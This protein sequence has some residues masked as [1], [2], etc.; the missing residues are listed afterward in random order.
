MG[1]LRPHFLAACRPDW[2]KM[3]CKTDPNSVIP[4]NISFYLT[5]SFYSL[6]YFSRGSDLL[7]PGFSP[8]SHSES[9]FS[10]RAHGCGRPLLALHVHL[11]HQVRVLHDSF[12]NKRLVSRRSNFE[13]W[14]ILCSSWLKS[15]PYNKVLLFLIYRK[16][17]TRP[18]WQFV[19]VKKFNQIRSSLLSISNIVE[20][21]DTDQDTFQDGKC[22]TKSLRDLDEERAHHDLHDLDIFRGS[23]SSH[24]LLASPYWCARLVFL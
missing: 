7:E 14:M 20:L 3:D 4:R 22:D 13:K 8:S 17:F 24:R 21:D 18:I 23:Y 19:R 11:S 10:L 9:L 2:S 12:S 16:E 15:V 1:R 5:L 6:V